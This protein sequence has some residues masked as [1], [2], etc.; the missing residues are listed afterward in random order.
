MKILIWKIFITIWNVGLC[1]LQVYFLNS[2]FRQI[3]E[4]KKDYKDII[5][6]RTIYEDRFIFAA[7]LHAMGLM[8]ERDFINY[9]SLFDLMELVVTPPRFYWFYLGKPFNPLHLGLVNYFHF[10][11]GNRRFLKTVP[12]KLFR[13]LFWRPNFGNQK[14]LN[15]RTGDFG[16]GLLTKREK[17]IW[18]NFGL[19]RINSFRN[20]WLKKRPRKEF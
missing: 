10:Q 5:Q 3:L 8:S 15:K 2:R 19:V 16:L 14:R 1:H 18:I 20:F 17:F 4:I 7:N 12:S 11:G 13:N 6:D 9:S